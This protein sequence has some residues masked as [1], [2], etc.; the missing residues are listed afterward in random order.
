MA[1]ARHEAGPLAGKRSFASGAENFAKG[2]ELR[3]PSRSRSVNG[4]GK[5]G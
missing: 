2:A 3:Y 5:R 4:T 1:R